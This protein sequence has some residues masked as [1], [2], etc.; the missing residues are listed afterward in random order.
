[1]IPGVSEVCVYLY[2]PVG[3]QN[4]VPPGQN[5]RTASDRA[6]DFDPFDRYRG[7]D[8]TKRTYKLLCGST[9]SAL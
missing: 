7:G 9:R 3:A 6:R 5:N 4:F 1:M 2:I 8:I